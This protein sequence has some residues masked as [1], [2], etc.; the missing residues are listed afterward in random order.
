MNPV[1]YNYMSGQSEFTYTGTLTDYD[2]TS[3][4]EQ[5]TALVLFTAGEYDETCPPTVRYYESFIPGSEMVVIPDAGHLT[6]QDNPEASNKAV[7]DFLKK[8]D[9]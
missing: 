5:I 7:G 3:R 2:V 9:P 8:H 1:I 6:M 4:L